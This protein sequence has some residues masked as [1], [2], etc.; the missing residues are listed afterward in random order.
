MTLDVN[1]YAVHAHAAGQLA[2]EAIDL[3][4]ERLRQELVEAHARHV[5][6]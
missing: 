5:M 4:E 6:R 3:V 2:T 1:G